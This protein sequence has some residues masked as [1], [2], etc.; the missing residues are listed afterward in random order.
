MGDIDLS[1]SNGTCYFAPGEQSSDNI[2]PCGN[3]ANGVYACCQATDYCLEYGACFNYTR[4]CPPA[5]IATTCSYYSSKE[6][7]SSLGYF[8]RTMTCARNSPVTADDSHCVQTAQHMCLGAPTRTSPTPVA[9]P[10]IHHTNNSWA[11]CNAKTRKWPAAPF[12]GADAPGQQR[13]RRLVRLGN[14]L[15]VGPRAG[16]S[17]GRRA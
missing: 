8:V 17:L 9:R 5:M 1:I 13:R 3:A 7:S 11:W 14:V 2:I 10:K 12:S 6:A 16:S 15:A 4:E